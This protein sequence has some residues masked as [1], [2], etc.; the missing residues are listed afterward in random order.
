MSAEDSSGQKQDEPGPGPR[1]DVIA[2]G[3]RY[4]ATRAAL[5]LFAYCVFVALTLLASQWGGN[6]PVDG[7]GAAG[8]ALGA[9]ALLLL[10]SF[11]VRTG[12]ARAAAN[13][14]RKVADPIPDKTVKTVERDVERAPEGTVVCC[15]GGGIKAASFTMGALQALEDARILSGAETVYGVSGGGYM[16]AAWAVRRK[17]TSWAGLEWDRDQL[18]TLRARTNYISAPGRARFDLLMSVTFGVLINVLL[19]G[20]LGATVGWLVGRFAVASGLASSG[21]PAHYERIGAN[22]WV[23]VPGMVLLLLTFVCFLVTRFRPRRVRGGTEGSQ[24]PRSGPRGSERSRSAPRSPAVDGARFLSELPNALFSLAILYFVAVPGL[25]WLSSRTPVVHI[26]DADGLLQN[27]DAVVGLITIFSAALGLSRSGA[28]ALAQPEG[29]LA[30][31][32]LVVRRFVAPWV[33]IVIVAG[34]IYWF[35]ARVTAREI[36]QPL[37]GAAVWL[38]ASCLLVAVSVVS[39]ARSANSTSLYAFYRDRLEYA[40][41]GTGSDDPAAQEPH[42]LQKQPGLALVATANATSGSALP[43]GRNGAPFVLSSQVGY[44]GGFPKTDHH[45]VPASRYFLQGTTPIGVADA[46][47]IS[48]AAVAPQAGRETKRIGAYRVLLALANIR[49][50]V[51]APNPYYLRHGST[52]T[53]L[54]DR[55]LLDLNRRMD[56]P[57]PLHIVQEAFGALRLDQPYLYLTDG[58]HYDNLGLVVALAGRPSTI[59]LLDGS[60]DTEDSFD[61]V[62]DAISSARMD[63]DVEVTFDPTPMRRGERKYPQSSSVLMWARYPGGTRCRI[64][65]IKAL[66]TEGLTFDLYSYRRRN[67]G[68]PTALRRLES[69]D[70]FDFEAYRQLGHCAAQEAVRTLN[71]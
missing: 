40:Y 14:A 8:F 33:A 6:A 49:L 29:P 36:A 21:I 16:A 5:V 61:A 45:Q 17:D 30:Q 53:G 1:Y 48:G 42:E 71:T 56:R 60:G 32:W 43:T 62:G 64:V 26:S 37:S 51:W 10:V 55:A 52:D 47:A 66:L 7:S 11:L 9:I 44:P 19:L 3:R 65:Y 70:E 35:T 25:I 69:L 63:L 24:S 13:E 41:L 58:G 15:S 20:G 50:G 18:A 2:A 39:W 28:K 59:Y 68:F 23:L 31:A 57:G 46:M 34:V 38:A 22:A 54:L 4:Q 27:K 12:G 67:P